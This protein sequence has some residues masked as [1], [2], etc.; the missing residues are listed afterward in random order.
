MKTDVFKKSKWY[1]GTNLLSL[2]SLRE[3]CELVSP[4]LHFQEDWRTGLEA[5]WLILL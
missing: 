4:V 2:P 1:W 5:G 3:E